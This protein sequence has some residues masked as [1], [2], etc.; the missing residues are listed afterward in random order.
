MDIQYRKPLALAYRRM[1][2][3]LFAPFNLGKW[4]VIGF[5]AWLAYLFESSFNFQFNLPGGADLWADEQL[6]TEGI[7]AFLADHMWVVGTI[8]VLILFAV[9]ALALVLLWVSA[10]FRFIFLDHVV[11][12]RTEIAKPWRN[13]VRQGNSL[14]VWWAVFGILGITVMIALFIPL[15]I[16]IMRM[17]ETVGASQILGVAGFVMLLFLLMVLFH[18]VLMLL[19][20]FV[21]PVMYKH[22]LRTTE[23]W[24]R[25]LPCFR[26]HPGPFVLYTL[27]L[28]GLHLG[29]GV[30]ILAVVILTC[31]C[32]GIILAIPYVG[33]VVL[34]PVTIFFR[35]FSL[36]FLRQFGEDFDLL[37]APM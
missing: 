32:A 5:S 25:F 28:I 4:C 18:F 30:A 19:S 17:N 23:A 6:W 2:L 3:I 35:S 33:A 14:F 13:H 15:I 7:E 26:S 16:L 12:N 29:I 10:R 1:K 8:V 36:Y 27:L 37:D 34:L 9:F 31:C 11:G 20:H 22:D 21:V 24:R